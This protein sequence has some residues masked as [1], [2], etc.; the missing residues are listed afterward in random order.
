MC[1]FAPLFGTIEYVRKSNKQQN[2]KEMANEEK[3][4]NLVEIALE[5]FAERGCSGVTMDDIAQAAHVSKRTLYETFDCKEEL[6]AECLTLVYARIN[7]THRQVHKHVNEP[8]LVAMYMLHEGTMVN[9]RYQRLMNEATRYYP[10][11]YT[12]FFNMHT[13]QLKKMLHKGFDYMR[14]HNYL[15]EV[16][17]V[18]VA[19]EFLC[20]YMERG[21]PADTADPKASA[22]RFNE[23]CFTYLRGMMNT[24]AIARLENE[25]EHF[26]KVMEEFGLRENEKQDTKR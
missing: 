24:D 8:M 5:L 11:I 17:D 19:V 12:R 1:I 10:D 22:K 4:S 13:E 16:V 2:N 25:E 23:V 9:R 20:E 14:E 7:D 21:C 15:R 26:H 6:L 3:R 18:D